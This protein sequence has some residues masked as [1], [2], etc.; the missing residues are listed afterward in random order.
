MYEQHTWYASWSYPRIAS[1]RCKSFYSMGGILLIKWAAKR[2]I[3]CRNVFAHRHKMALSA[4]PAVPGF[5]R[6][7]PYTCQNSSESAHFI[8][9]FTMVGQTNIEQV[10]T[11]NTSTYPGLCATQPKS[12]TK[13]PPW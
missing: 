2:A 9:K 3:A 10:G 11:C 1:W 8:P 5:L 12:A 6:T 4:L 7:H 13:Y